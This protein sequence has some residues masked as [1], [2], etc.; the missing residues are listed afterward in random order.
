MYKHKLLSV[1]PGSPTVRHLQA[2][3]IDYHQFRQERRASP[4]TA[5]VQRIEHWQGLRLKHTHSDLYEHPHYRQALDFLLEDLYAPTQF[6]RRDDDLDRVFPVLV[7]MVPENALGTVARLVELNLFTQRLDF[8]LAATLRERH[9]DG[10][11]N[12]ARYCEC[13]RASHRPEE[14]H[15]QIGMILTIGTELEAYVRSRFL[16][17][18]L[19]VTESAAKL[20]GLGQLHS[21]LTRGMAA[22]RR[23][24]KVAPLLE[25]VTAREHALFD[26]LYAG[27]DHPYGFEGHTRKGDH[28]AVR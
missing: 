28:A 14:R 9:P 18:S 21:F 26:R 24:G 23:L 27:D 16:S 12:E 13:L 22:F 11:V 3:L 20:A 2:C 5:Q 10:E 8:S 7:K 17:F 6:T 15:A 25:M 4:L 19:G 1:R